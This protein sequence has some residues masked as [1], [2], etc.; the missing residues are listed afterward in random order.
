MPP[1]PEY[2][3]RS[4]YIRIV[5][6]F[7]KVESEHLSQS[8]CHIRIAAEVKINLQ[9]IGDGCQPCQGHVHL[10]HGENTVADLPH[11]IGNEKFFPKTADKTADSLRDFA[12]T[13]FAERKFS[14]NI[15]EFDDR[16]CHQLW[17]ERDVQQQMNEILLCSFRISVNIYD[18]GHRLE[19]EKG[20]SYR[21]WNA[22]Q[23]NVGAEN[24]VDVFQKEVGVFEHT[25][26]GNIEDYCRCQ[27][28]F[29]PRPTASHHPAEYVV[30]TYTANH[31]QNVDR[32]AESIE[33][34]TGGNKKQVLRCHPGHQIISDE[35]YRQKDK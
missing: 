33:N 21:Q 29:S 26:N 28:G 12:D 18:I 32:L 14:R 3:N 20:D 23:R 7:F 1:S 24:S 6:I 31:N 5:E 11:R 34:Q 16:T 17:K 8:N 4:G 2:R 15:V 25:D 27:G 10:I 19:C 22:G 30:C 13:C 35:Y 9:R